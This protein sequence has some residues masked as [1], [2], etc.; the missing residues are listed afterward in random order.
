MCQYKCL[1]GNSKQVQKLFLKLPKKL[2]YGQLLSILLNIFHN[3][4]YFLIIMELILKLTSF[5]LNLSIKK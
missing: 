3:N 1:S 2:T 5:L 4:L